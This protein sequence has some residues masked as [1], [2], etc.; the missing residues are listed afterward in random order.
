MTDVAGFTQLMRANEPQ[1]LALLQVDV[2]ILKRVFAEKRGEIVKIAGDGILAL[3]PEAYLALSACQQAQ[4]ELENSSLKH[5]MAIHYGRVT[6]ADGDVYGDTVNVCSR[7][8]QLATPGTIIMSDT[9]AFE[10]QGVRLDLPTVSG[11]V[12]LKGIDEKMMVHCFG[13]NAQLPREKNRQLQLAIVVAI[14]A[15]VAS[16]F[17]W[18]ASQRTTLDELSSRIGGKKGSI[19]ATNNEAQDIDEMLDQAFNDIWEERDEFDKVRDE[20]V[21]KLDPDSVLKWL[22]ESP[23]GQR[24]RGREER[25]KWEKIKI[26]IEEGRAIVGKSANVDQIWAATFKD[27][28]VTAEARKAFAEEFRKPD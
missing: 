4:K 3:F 13:R 8:E 24:E 7:L 18:F 10:I 19:K 6:M 27:E 15:V 25:Q 26:V 21:T 11:K 20:A 14:V 16:T 22:D 12:R 17:A 9:A 2:E 23:F 5:R 1:T 28:K